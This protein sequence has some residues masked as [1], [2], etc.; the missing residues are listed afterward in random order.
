[1]K[2]LY[3]EIVPVAAERIV[4]ATH[5]MTLKLAGREFLFLDAPGH[6]R[7]HLC[8]VDSRTG[9]VFC[10]DTFGL[11]YRDFDT[12]RG[13]FIIASSTPVQFDP[14]AM[15]ASI[16]RMLAYQPEAMYLTHYSRVEDVPRLGRDLYAWI[17]TMVAVAQAADGQPDRHDRMRAGLSDA[18]VE[19]AQAHGCAMTPERIR[20]LLAIDIELNAQGLGV[21][22]DTRKR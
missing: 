18:Y 11:S 19:R 1:M 7:H 8:M 17:D 9:H 4:E 22:L 20:E 13:A 6:A 21:W 12:E 16:A 14:E 3:G 5:G 10:G 15:R 2:R